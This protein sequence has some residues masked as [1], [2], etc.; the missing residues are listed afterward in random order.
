VTPRQKNK[1]KN[2]KSRNRKGI[3]LPKKY[4]ENGALL[5]QF[6]TSNEYFSRSKKKPL[7]KF[8]LSAL[9][10]TNKM[11]SLDLSQTNKMRSLD[12]SQTNKMPITEEYNWLQLGPTCIPLGETD[13]PARVLV[14]GR[15]T[16]IAIVP[17]NPD[18]I[19]LGTGQGGIWKTIDGGRNWKAISDQTESLA[20]GALVIDPKHP[21]VLYAGTGEGNLIQTTPTSYYGVGVLKTKNG[22]KEWNL[23]GETI[24]N[25]ARFFRLSVNPTNTDRIFAATSKGLYRSLDGGETWKPMTN[26]LPE[27]GKASSDLI[28]H[29]KEPH[30]I[31]Y[32]AFWADGIYKTKN[33]NDKNPEWIKISKGISVSDIGRIALGLDTSKIDSD[34]LY[35]LMDNGQEKVKYFYMT[36]DNGSTWI[37]I[38]FPEII[39]G[40]ISYHPKGTK[41]IGTQ[42]SYNLNIIVDPQESN[43]VYLS[44]VPLLKAIRNRRS[45]KWTFIDIGRNI[46]TDNHTFAFH[47]TDNKIIFTGN[48]GG[49]YKST[50]GGITWKDTLNEGLCITQFTFMDQHP[51]SDA[52]IIGGTQDNGTLQF[53]NNPAFYLCDESDGGFVAIDPENP[54]RV[55]HA[56]IGPDIMRSDEGGSF[57]LYEKGGSWKRPQRKSFGTIQEGTSLFFPPFTLDQ[58]NSNNIAL[59]TSNLYLYDQSLKKWD[60]SEPNKWEVIEFQELSSKELISAINYVN[61]NLIYVGTTEGKIFLLTKVNN[62]WKSDILESSNDGALPDNYI[63]DIATYPENNKYLKNSTIIVVL[64]GFIEE[65]DPPRVWRG[66]ISDDKIVKW[67][68]ISGNDNANGK[69]LPNSPARVLAIDFNNPDIIYIG[70]DIG[71]FRTTDEGESWK[72]FGINLPKCAVL[73]MRLL[74]YKYDNNSMRLLRVAT[75]GRGMWEVEL[76]QRKN[77]NQVDLYVR[78]HIMDTGRFTPSLSKL[79]SSFEDPLRNI[80]FNDEGNIKFDDNYDYLFWWMCAD[81]KIDSPFY[82]MDI[83][84]VDYVKFEY[85]IKNKNPIATLKNRVY[86]QVHNR[87]IKDASNVSIKL[88]YAKVIDSVSD[89]IFLP[90]IPQDF[91]TKFSDASVDLD[92]GLWKQIGIKSLP[93]GPKTLTYTEPTVVCWEWEPPI[94]IIDEQVGLLVVIDSDSKEDQIPEENKKFFDIKELVQKEKHIGVRVLKV[95]SPRQLRT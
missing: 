69:S 48:D 55:F 39:I 36:E 6:A 53:R 66:E 94:D 50:D 80:K 72:P 91:W 38:D 95:D 40:G 20:I 35:T 31:V 13:S 88:L 27:I 68:N 23:K 83:D 64:G 15:V 75:H 92:L 8:R 70:T 25:G 19:Y 45:G 84:D 34:I 32:A 79:K 5:R 87:G 7:S 49:I 81:I 90:D 4:L 67:K 22:G 2:T 17:N 26:G 21:E 14:S 82:Q 93:D 54:T 76:D 18:I 47:P 61:S 52:L 42:G 62:K 63:M 89:D 59:G 3:K 33:A 24:F 56:R 16:S 41:G 86:V 65:V 1:K 85:R 74:N 30:N 78:D 77:K 44:A 29:P 57:G 12:L 10:Q 71:V 28:I 73:D 37:S 46:H 43:I 9:R 60:E 58:T 51:T 11:R